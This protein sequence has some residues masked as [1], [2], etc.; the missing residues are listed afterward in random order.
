MIV[1]PMKQK[2]FKCRE[3]NC[4]AACEL[5]E[6]KTEGCRCARLQTRSVWG[7]EARRLVGLRSCTAVLPAWLW[8]IPLAAC[9]VAPNVVDEALPAVRVSVVEVAPHKVH[10]RYPGTI[11][12]SE[13][14]RTAFLHT[15]ILAERHVE[16]G[17]RVAAGEVLAVLHNPALAP[18]VVATRGQVQEFS[19]RI[20]QLERDLDRTRALRARAVAAEAT[21]DRLET[22]LKAVRLGREQAAARLDEARK[23]A[24]ELILRAP[25]AATVVD[26]LAEPG[27]FIAAGQAVLGLAGIAGLEV[28]IRVP[29]HLRVLLTPGMPVNVTPALRTAHDTGRSARPDGQAGRIHSVGGADVGLVPVIVALEVDGLQAGESVHVH[30]ELPSPSGL[31]VPLAA[32][33]DLGDGSPHLL[34]LD[35]EDIVHRV[36]IVPGRMFDGTIEVQGGLAAGDRVIVAGQGRVLPGVRAQVQR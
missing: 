5:G 1:D 34:R 9:D 11:R 30:L 21:V 12:A 4:T 22:E 32:V 8:L 31:R 27:D 25:F 29:A 3:S 19:A 7:R 35:A 13:R 2:R 33:V 14:A 28:E 20:A 18:A 17:Q 16:R 10:Q 24:D 15:G 6:A 23:Q 26:L 36:S